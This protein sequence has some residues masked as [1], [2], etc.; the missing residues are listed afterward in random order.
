M[1]KM[2]RNEKFLNYV[3]VTKRSGDVRDADGLFFPG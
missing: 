3:Y 1:Y 2:I